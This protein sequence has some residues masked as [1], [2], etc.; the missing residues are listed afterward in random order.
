MN[1]DLI[2][3]AM[4]LISDLEPGTVLD[5]ELSELA[6][7]TLEELVGVARREQEKNASCLNN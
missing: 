2:G 3:K 6:I 1:K 5:K 4:L 7:T